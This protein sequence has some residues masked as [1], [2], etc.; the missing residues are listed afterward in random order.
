MS[1]NVGSRTSSAATLTDTITGRTP[2]GRS[3]PT[4]PLPGWPRRA[5]T[6][7]R[8]PSHWSGP[9]GGGTPSDRAAPGGVLPPEQGLDGDD[10]TAVQRHARLVEEGELSEPEGRHD[11]ALDVRHGVAETSPGVLHAQPPGH[12]V[13]VRQPGA[14]RR[15]G[16]GRGQPPWPSRS[17]SRLPCLSKGAAFGAFGPDPEGPLSGCGALAYVSV[18]V[19][20][21]HRRPP[22]PRRHRRRLPDQARR[23]R[24]GPRRC[25]RRRPS[26]ARLLGRRWP[27]SGWLGLHVPEEH[28]GSGFGLEE[29]VV[30]VEEL[31][32]AVAPGPFVP[33]RD[34]QRRA[35]RGRP[36]SCQAAAAA[37][38]R[39]RLRRRRGRARRRRSTVRRRH[40]HRR[41]RRRA[42]RRP[43]RRAARRRPAT[44]SPSS[45][46]GRR[47]H[48]RH[49]AEPRPHPARRRGSPSTARRPTV[50]PG[51]R[52]LLVDLARVDPLGRGGRRRP[53]V[54]RDGGR[55]RQG[56]R[57][58]RPADRDV[59]GGQAPLRQHARG[60]RAGDRARCGTR[61]GPAPAAATSSR[62]AAAVAATLAAPAADLCANLNIQVHGGIGFTWEHDAHLYLRRAT[63]LGASSTP[64][65]G[66]D[67][68]HRP[69][70]ARGVA[71]GARHRAAARGR[72]DPRRGAGVRRRAIKDLDADEQR[73]RADRDRLRHAA[74]ARSRRAATPAPSSSS[75]SSR[76]SPRAGVKRPPYGITGWVILTLIQHA[77]RGPGRPLG[78]ARRSTRRSSGAS[79]SASP[80]PAPTPPASRPRRPASTAA[81]W[82]TAR[83]CGPAAPTCAGL[84]FATVR[85]NP[86]VPKHDGH[87]DDGHRHARRGRRGP[88]AAR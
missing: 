32:R 10:V 38:P 88:A 74:L 60:H 50:L 16:P 71:A 84:G 30:V 25:S 52:R 19:D 5:P 68:R 35:R 31:G 58:V 45:S 61:P 72:A 7:P 42:R 14:A 67:R 21:H 70:P 20:R 37:R 87:H 81:G 2:A 46:V 55:V 26:D 34:R 43:R 83:R 51:A 82:S 86:D 17:S 15:G 9:R 49:A 85:T 4:G 63:A 27:T 24:R 73:A 39:R 12:R 48:G 8:R 36:T 18:H 65:R 13:A 56:A 75:S 76:S 59:P 78:A 40:A 57:A 22:G 3:S 80:T 44:T 6:A 11:I 62:Y 53:R 54:H 29:L 69:R 64:R 66:R 33:D 28:G 79:C 77:D 41:R 1:K 23:P 47:R